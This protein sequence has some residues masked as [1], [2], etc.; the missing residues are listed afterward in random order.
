M[1][2][3]LTLSTFLDQQFYCQMAL[4][5][6]GDDIGYVIMLLG[7]VCHGWGI[8]IVTTECMNR[9]T[10]CGTI[11]LYQS[12][13]QSCR[14]K[15][16][17]NNA[18]ALPNPTMKLMILIKMDAYFTQMWTLDNRTPPILKFYSVQCCNLPQHLKQLKPNF[19]SFHPSSLHFGML[20]TTQPP[21]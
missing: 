14:H 1:L 16:K 20:Q 15:Y 8:M 10:E 21:L 3:F 18:N 17:V 5:E 13:K 9:M 2:F 7:K 4:M 11:E 6:D 19:L 12:Q